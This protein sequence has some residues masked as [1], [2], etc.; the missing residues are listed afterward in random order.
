MVANTGQQYSQV[1]RWVLS[2]WRT[3]ATARAKVCLEGSHG[4]IGR[5]CCLRENV[6]RPFEK[7]E[8]AIFGSKRGGICKDDEAPSRSC[9]GFGGKKQLYA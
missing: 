1:Y 3:R 6:E 9:R 4:D 5:G 8:R 2:I 7:V